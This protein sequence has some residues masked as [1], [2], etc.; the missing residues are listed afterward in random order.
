MNETK[1]AS[2][3]S[4]TTGMANTMTRGRRIARVCKACNR[5]VPAYPGRYPAACPMCGGAL[6][7]SCDEGSVNEGV[8]IKPDA[9]YVIAADVV[10]VGGVLKPVLRDVLDGPFPS[11]QA[12]KPAMMRG[13]P[14]A[15]IRRGDVILDAD[16]DPYSVL[17]SVVY[18]PGQEPDADAPVI[19]SAHRYVEPI[20]ALIEVGQ[21]RG[22]SIVVPYAEVERQV[23]AGVR[24]IDWYTEGTDS[25]KRYRVEGPHAPVLIFEF[26]DERHEAR[27]TPTDQPKRHLGFDPRAEMVED[28]G[29]NEGGFVEEGKSMKEDIVVPASTRKALERSVVAKINRDNKSKIGGEWDVMIP[30]H[31]MVRA[32]EAVGAVYPSN[33]AGAGQWW[34]GP[35]SAIP[36]DVL[37]G[38]RA[39][40][41]G[42]L[43][44]K[45]FEIIKVAMGITEAALTPED[46]YALVA[47]RFAEAGVVA[48]ASLD[49]RGFTS[50]AT[51]QPLEPMPAT[52]TGNTEEDYRASA[53]RNKRDNRAKK[54]TAIHGTTRF[55]VG[56]RK[57]RVSKDVEADL[58]RK[59]NARR[60]QAKR[61]AAARKYHN[62]PDGRR[63]HRD[64]GHYN[65]GKG[66][67]KNEEY[68]DSPWL[69]NALG[70]VLTVE[71]ARQIIDERDPYGQD[72]ARW[73][74]R[75]GGDGGGYVTQRDL[76]A[77]ERI[78]DG[79]FARAGMDIEFTRH[80]LDRVNDRRN[81]RQITI[82]ELSAIF[83][84]VFQRHA[85]KIKGR[86]ADWEAVIAD[87]TSNINIPFVLNYDRRNRSLELVAKTVMRKRGFKTRNKRLTVTT[88]AERAE[89]ARA[90]IA[91]LTESDSEMRELE[92]RAALG[93]TKAQSR[94]ARMQQRVEDPE[95]PWNQLGLTK[96][97][98]LVVWAVGSWKAQ[99][100]GVKNL[101]WVNLKRLGFRLSLGQYEAARKSLSTK[102]V[103]N[104]AGSAT[105]KSKDM[106]KRLGELTGTP[107]YGDGYLRWV[108]KNDGP[109]VHAAHAP[110]PAK[111]EK[112]P[113][114]YLSRSAPAL[115][116][117]LRYLTE[118]M[119]ED[120]LGGVFFYEPVS[121]Y[122]E[123]KHY[124][125]PLER[126]KNGNLKVLIVTW[127]GG[128][129]VPNKAKQDT[130]NPRDPLWGAKFAGMRTQDV[131]PKV[132][133]RFKAKDI[134]LRE[135]VDENIVQVGYKLTPVGR[136][137][138]DLTENAMGTHPHASLPPLASGM[139]MEE[140][141]VDDLFDSILRRLIVIESSD[142]L[143]D[144]NFDEHG[145]IYL[146]FDPSLSRK[147]VDEVH[148]WVQ[149][150]HQ[151]LSLVAS[152]NGSLPEE[153]ARADW[154]VMFL[155]GANIDEGTEPGPDPAKYARPEDAEMEGPR[156]Q[157]MV[158]APPT[159]VDQVATT[160]DTNKLMKG[161][162]ESARWLTPLEH[163]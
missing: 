29:W 33:P 24:G 51:L 114:P 137:M 132:L 151:K 133:D 16:K 50:P 153:Q 4:V 76:D 124:V 39:V 32:A 95:M 130:L 75:G 156:R 42:K 60:G 1:R 25:G 121:A 52:V 36:T 54:G 87:L 63:L 22:E 110:E 82:D 3:V 73:V 18:V 155:P 20:Q 26:D 19:A 15:T 7:A 11:Y 101:R 142:V 106:R 145:S 40:L 79:L 44:A 12:A 72:T 146:F 107:G 96:I 48:E 46:I 69:E 28:G 67:R 8:A 134:K 23:P 100:G 56:G 131:P 90:K 148:K 129:R 55:V 14:K 58:Q 6:E 105:R 85:N 35:V 128:R 9:Y 126:L 80:F 97:E 93:D 141:S 78:L 139:A 115:D 13:G 150:E 34:R 49:E 41:R 120:G 109:D 108:L 62:S 140:P 103:F 102:G 71:E 70:A 81:K 57:R 38:L 122:R 144:V 127:E 68:P 123:Q 138:L 45:H 147:E 154:W 86:G 157:M 10:M 163:A 98:S 61:I 125:V 118:P 116:S 136:K 117:S 99:H 91:S 104:K 47:D 21:P 162:G 65:R 160:V 64:L 161:L 66:R 43:A 31:A 159:P 77:L 2:L 92:R 89:A 83:H 37:V 53:F 84:E 111:P 27:L 135:S 158:S 59:R 30:K 112:A 94:L 119:K 17:E 88:A 143:E 113:L 149:H 74:A 152:P 5:G